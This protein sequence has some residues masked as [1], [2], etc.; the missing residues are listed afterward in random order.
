LIQKQKPRHA[1]G[2]LLR[3]VLLAQLAAAGEAKT[4]ECEAE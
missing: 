4:R 1:G 2:V 3:D